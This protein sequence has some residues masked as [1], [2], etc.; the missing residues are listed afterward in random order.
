MKT[1]ILSILAALCLALP[2]S[3][4]AQAQNLSTGWLE[5]TE[6]QAFLDR[7][8]YGNLVPLTVEAGLVYGHLR[9]NAVFGRRPAG[10][11]TWQLRTGRS[12]AAFADLNQGYLAQGYRLVHHQ[13]FNTEGHLLNQG[14]WYR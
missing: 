8:G 6:Y 4:P 7:D 5:R 3:Q 2:T 12:D 1:F 10:V 13:R 9:N 14:I 11:S